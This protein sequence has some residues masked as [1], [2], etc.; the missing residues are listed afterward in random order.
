MTY[1][2]GV[3]D[4]NI[5]KLIKF[6]GNHNGIITMSTI[7]PQSRYGTIDFEEDGQ[8]VKSF[9]EKPEGES[10]WINGGFFVCESEVFDY[11]SNSSECIFERNPLEKM[12]LDKKLHAY[13]HDG[14]LRKSI[15]YTGDWTA[16]YSNWAVY[17]DQKEK[18]PEE[19]DIWRSYGTDWP[20]AGKFID[21]VQ[22]MAVYQRPGVKTKPAVKVNFK[23]DVL[24]QKT[25]H[26]PVV[27]W[28]N[29]ALPRLRLGFDSRSVH[30]FFK[31]QR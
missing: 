15:R 22:L 21:G 5:D 13:K 27:E 23:K 8:L 18:E 25:N 9:E 30:I 24:L 28:Y 11:I 2:D 14:F 3:S 10:G 29:G 4:I 16:A 26:A 1:G 12:S 7:Q 19:L 6:H 17:H 20:V 31:C